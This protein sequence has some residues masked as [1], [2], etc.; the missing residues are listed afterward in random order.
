MGRLSLTMGRVGRAVRATAGLMSLLALAA[1]ELKA[2]P[3]GGGF[4]GDAVAGRA[5]AERVCAA[6][7]GLAGDPVAPAVPRLAGQY[8]E[9][10]QKQLLAFRAG[11]GG[12]PKRLSPVMAPI[13]AALSLSDIANAAAYYAGQPAGQGGARDPRRL[14]LGRRVYLEGDPDRDLPACVTCHR[15][16]GTGI[17][18]DFPVVGGQSPDYLDD[19]LANWEAQRGHPGKLMS[20]IAPHLPPDERAAVADYIAQLRPD[21]SQASIASR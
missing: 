13:A 21:R 17:R 6:C 20:L 16:T 14:E 15:P 12:K 19:Q 3:A 1:C 9:Y 10:L 2:A 4:A 11:P 18:P 5:L 8:P 7:H